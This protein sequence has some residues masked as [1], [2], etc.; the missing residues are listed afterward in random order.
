M[1][2]CSAVLTR[3]RYLDV[4]TW[5]AATWL[6]PVAVQIVVAVLLALGWVVSTWALP[7][8]LC[9]PFITSWDAALLAGTAVTAVASL[10]TGAVLVSAKSLRRRGLGLAVGASGLAVLAG[11]LAYVGW[12]LPFVEPPA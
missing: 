2:M 9:F 12:V 10:L 6:A 5:R 8:L 1:C 4:G 7:I 11:M 3:M